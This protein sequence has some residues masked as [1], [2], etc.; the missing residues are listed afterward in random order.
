M[1]APPTP[2]SM[3]FSVLRG[4]WRLLLLGPVEEPSAEGACRVG[5]VR[6]DEGEG[7]RLCRRL[8]ADHSKSPVPFDARGATL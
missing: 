6:D 7:V 2:R 8:G 3:T 1:P 5:A 4:T